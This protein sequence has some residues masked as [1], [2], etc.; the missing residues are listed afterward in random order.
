MPVPDSNIPAE[1]SAYLARLRFLA[2]AL[3]HSIDE[4][5]DKRVATDD[6]GPDILVNWLREAL[7]KA[8]AGLTDEEV[9]TP[10]P[11]ELINVLP[12]PRWIAQIK[13]LI[14]ELRENATLPLLI[15][16]FRNS[17]ESVATTSR[18]A[19]CQ[20][21]G[22]KD[23]WHAVNSYRLSLQ[24]PHVSERD[25]AGQLKR[26]EAIISDLETYPV[27]KFLAEAFRYMNYYRL[28]RRSILDTEVF[29]SWPPMLGPLRAT[30]AALQARE[31][32]KAINTVWPQFGVGLAEI[33]P[34]P[35]DS[36]LESELGRSR[37][38]D[39]I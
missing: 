12:A 18:V 8:R 32:G 36:D 28:N 4:G 20:R 34:A 27:V 16:E 38:V 3:D 10:P 7:G 1:L 23:L 37:P 26:F 31:A 24:A 21:K 35:Q 22:G 9:S 14:G 5:K 29:S 13:G 6:L 25:Q 15:Q 2:N 19:L 39:A 30:L 11:W 33:S 17:F